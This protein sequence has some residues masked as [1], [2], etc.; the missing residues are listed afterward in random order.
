KGFS[1]QTPDPGSCQGPTT[2]SAQ[3]SLILATGI[4]QTVIESL[5]DPL[6]DQ[7]VGGEECSLLRVLSGAV[8]QRC[9]SLYPRVKESGSSLVLTHEQD[10]LT[11]RIGLSARH[12]IGE[13]T[14]ENFQEQSDQLV[15]TLREM[16]SP[17]LCAVVPLA[18]RL[19]MVEQLAEAIFDKA[20]TDRSFRDIS[21]QILL[22]LDFNLDFVIIFPDEYTT[23][24]GAFTPSTGGFQDELAANRTRL[25]Y[26]LNKSQAALEGLRSNPQ[27]DPVRKMMVGNS[28]KK[29]TIMLQS[30]DDASVPNAMLLHEMS[31]CRLK[32]HIV[33]FARYECEQLSPCKLGIL[34][35]DSLSEGE[36]VC[37]REL[38]RQHLFGSI[39]LIG[40]LCN[41]YLVLGLM[42][43]QSC[44]CPLVLGPV[45]DAAVHKYMD[46]EIMSSGKMGT[47]KTQAQEGIAQ[48]PAHLIIHYLQQFHDTFGTDIYEVEPDSSYQ[49]NYV[50]IEMAVVLLNTVPALT[51][52]SFAKAE[53]FPSYRTFTLD[54]LLDMVTHI[55][56]GIA[57]DHSHPPR[58][59]AMLHA[60]LG[61]DEESSSESL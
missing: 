2:G 47:L 33:N 43:A 57:K 22:E 52:P 45:L 25:E 20:C 18:D 14:A 21:G 58:I 11:D 56:H 36:N 49:F 35:N 34:P 39:R 29:Y 40:T 13:M 48:V 3:R 24:D 28:I 6:S 59:R 38:C 55:F 8:D 30:L 60:A 7:S 23:S 27:A 4:H 31:F 32:K 9:H 1:T 19:L 44:L 51:E 16:V 10:L 53:L 17:D 61:M 26:L 12:I 15:D 41:N 54:N 42:L 50:S 5:R 37:R 46:H